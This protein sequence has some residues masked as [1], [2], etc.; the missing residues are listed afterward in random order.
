MFGR[1][2]AISDKKSRDGV[3]AGIVETIH[4]GI[5]SSC[6]GK[7]ASIFKGLNCSCHAVLN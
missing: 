3:E 2:E 7:N 4:T 5:P 1:G 6:I